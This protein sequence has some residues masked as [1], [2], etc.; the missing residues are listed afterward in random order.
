MQGGAQARAPSVATPLLS[1]AERMQAAESISGAIAPATPDG[2]ADALAHLAKP[3]M[4]GVPSHLLWDD[5]S[6]VPATEV[7]KKK[8]GWGQKYSMEA[9]A[10]AES[11]G[12]TE[13][14]LANLGLSL[15]TMTAATM[16]VDEKEAAAVVEE[17]S[18]VVVPEDDEG[19]AASEQVRRSASWKNRRVILDDDDD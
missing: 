19:E 12:V 1:L 9:G 14:T 10:S 4:P 7:R 6:A 2:K 17:D 18:K 16:E 15:P 5:V 3:I 11:R 13:I 8:K